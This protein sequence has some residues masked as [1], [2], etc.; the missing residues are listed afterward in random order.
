MSDGKLFQSRRAA[1]ANV[2]YFVYDQRP[3][4]E[5]RQNAIVWRRRRWRVGSRH[6]S[7]R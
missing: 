2:K 7:A 1:A 3:V 6:S 5:C 4:L